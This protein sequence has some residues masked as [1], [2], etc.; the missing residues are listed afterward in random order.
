[1]QLTKFIDYRL[2]D[3]TEFI[4]RFIEIDTFFIG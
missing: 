4:D 2:N 3:Y 1:M